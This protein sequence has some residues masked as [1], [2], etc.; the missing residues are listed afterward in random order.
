MKKFEYVIKDKEGLHAML[1][2]I[3]AA[4][5]KKFES[6]I[7][8]SKNGKMTDAREFM[9]VMGLGIKCGNKVA[10]EISGLDEEAAYEAIK[11]FFRE[12]L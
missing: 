2:G 8:L 10:V 5:A 4:E 9:A 1:V 6:K 12:N 11:M 7:V 3:L